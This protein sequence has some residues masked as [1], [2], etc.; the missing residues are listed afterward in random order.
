MTETDTNPTKSSTRA[1]ALRRLTSWYLKRIDAR[2]ADVA[3]ARKRLD[4]FAGLLSP[5]DDVEIRADSVAGLR[6]EWLTPAG[7]GTDKLLLYWH[8]GGYI[9]GSCRSHRSIV[10]HIA[11]QAGVRALVAEYRLAPE[12]RFPAAID[13]SVGVYHELLQQGMQPRDI[14]VAGDSAGGGLTV[15]MM[16][17]LR[18]AGLPLPRAAALLSPWLDLSGSGDSMQSRRGQDPWFDPDDLPTVVDYYC[19]D[20]QRRNPLVSPV[21]ANVAGL[22]R[23]LIQVGDDEILLSDSQRFADK[24]RE[25]GIDVA[26]DVWP[27]MWHVWQ[28]F[29][30]LMP[31]SEAAIDKLAAFIRE[32]LAA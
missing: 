22:P 2:T 12:H 3:E 8:G 9:M 17:S 23:T 18:H 32:S 25:Q 21:F 16:L 6:A 14:A 26:L 31:E 28:M 24:L 1:R 5:A 19:D 29:V 30:G 13:D 7:A 15:A 20:D 27:R 10:S 11:R 4:F